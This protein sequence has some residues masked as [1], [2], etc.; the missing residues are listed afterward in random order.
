MV[1]CPSCGEE[2]EE[3]VRRPG[4]YKC[5]SDGCD[6]NMDAVGDYVTFEKLERYAGE[7]EAAAEEI[8]RKKSKGG[9]IEVDSLHPR[10]SE[11]PGAFKRMGSRLTDWPKS[12]TLKSANLGREKLREFNENRGERRTRRLA[13]IE[14][15]ES[16]ASERLEAREK[17]KMEKL[18]DWREKRGK[19]KDWRESWKEVGKDEWGK[20]STAKVFSRASDKVSDFIDLRRRKRD[21]RRGEKLDK[22][23][24][25]EAKKEEAIEE[26]QKM[27]NNEVD[28]YA[29]EIRIMIQEIVS[30]SR[31]DDL[32]KNSERALGEQSRILL[33]E[34]K[35]FGR[36]LK[37]PRKSENARIQLQINIK[38][39][40][41]IASV[42]LQIMARI[43]MDVNEIRKKLDLG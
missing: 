23:E 39:L 8:R 38:K 11:R 5:V 42:T 1:L 3:A 12:P 30:N 29:E 17:D 13:R 18:D 35:K 33:S 31:P 37:D 6:I 28:V 25:E 19:W 24:E 16:N 43:G 9:P 4:F 32:E 40:E 14:E 34:Q 26:I 15:R 21:I 7:A 20:S 2:L 10:G 36:Y 41:I 27:I 22:I